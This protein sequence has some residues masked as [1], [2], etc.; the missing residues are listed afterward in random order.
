SPSLGGAI[1][2]IFGAHEEHEELS[3]S[4][5]RV[6]RDLDKPAENLGLSA[7]L[8]SAPPRHM[9]GHHLSLPLHPNRN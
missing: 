3:T 2:A 9:G 8:F 1:G 5:H 6:I 7:H 4:P